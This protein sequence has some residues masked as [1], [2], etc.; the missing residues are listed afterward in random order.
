M[1]IKEFF[2]GKKKDNRIRTKKPLLS[3]EEHLLIQQ[4]LARNKIEI[5]YEK[6]DIQIIVKRKFL[7][8]EGSLYYFPYIDALR[9]CGFII[10]DRKKYVP[11]PPTV[12][13][14]QVKTYE[15]ESVTIILK[16]IS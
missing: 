9:E 3:R 10:D 16:D 13:Q 14:K 8:D 12:I 7:V 15:E 4:S 6:V 11:S 1:T 5:P 2:D